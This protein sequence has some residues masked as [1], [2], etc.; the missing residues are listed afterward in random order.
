M[1]FVIHKSMKRHVNILSWDALKN[2]KVK[3]STTFRATNRILCSVI[4]TE[5]I[6]INYY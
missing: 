2:I 4:Y 5:I 1:T 6:E 3:T